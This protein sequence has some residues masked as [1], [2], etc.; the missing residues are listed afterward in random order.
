MIEKRSAFVLP[1]MLL[2]FYTSAVSTVETPKY[3]PIDV[4]NRSVLETEDGTERITYTVEAAE[5]RFEDKEITLLKRKAETSGTD[6]TTG[7]VYFVHLDDD[8][9]KLHKV[10]AELGSVFGTATAVLSP[11]VLFLPASLALGDSWE[12]MLESEVILT[13]PVSVLSVYEVVAVEDVVTPAG[14]FENCLKIKLDSR[15]VSTLSVTRSTSYQWMAPNV[16]IV[17]VETDQEIVF[18]LVNSNSLTDVSI[19]DVT[20]DGTVNILDLV[21]VASLFGEVN[22]E[23]DVNVDGVVNILDLTL[24]AQNFSN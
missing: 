3:Y 4:G 8:G 2:F 9:V 23:A 18:N 21:F 19:Y 20:G 11:P 6:E 24:I 13:G 14:T 16:G 22:A 15:T 17:R 10:V 5:E 7:E 12:F 1:S